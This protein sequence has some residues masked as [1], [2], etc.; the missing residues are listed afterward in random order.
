MT[1]TIAN[2][3]KQ[4]KFTRNDAYDV[5]SIVLIA[6]S[7]VM[8]V[9]RFL[10]VST[11]LVQA[12]KDLAL[13]IAFYFTEL[14][15]F[16]GVITPTVSVIPD[17]LQDILPRT[18]E[19]FYPILQAYGKAL[20]SW[21]DIKASVGV[22]LLNTANVLSI[23]FM[24][25]PLLLC[26]GWLVVQAYQKPNNDY[27]KKTKP[28]ERFERFEEKR[29][30]PVKEYVCGY[31]AYIKEHTP[32][33][34]ILAFLWLYNLNV[35]TIAVEL[36][37]YLLYLCVALTEIPSFIRSLYVQIV[38]LVCDL[39]VMFGFFPWWVFA[40]IG[41]K[42]FDAIRQSIGMAALRYYE[43]CNR[44]FL[45]VYLGALFLVGKQ[46]SKKTTIITDMALTQEII[47]REEARERLSARDK[48]FPFFPWQ[49]V[50]VFYRLTQK[51]HK[52]PTLA[53]YRA[54]VKKLRTTFEQARAGLITKSQEKAMRRRFK[55]LYGYD[56]TNLLFSYDYEKYGLTY[57]DNLTCISIFE[58]IEA[59]IQLFYIYAAPTS[60]LFGNY[61][62]R[63]DLM[64]VD[65]GNFP[66]FDG[67]FFSRSAEEIEELSQ[68]NHVANLDGFRLGN[69]FDET[70]PTRNGFEVG[71]LVVT[72]WAKE[73]GN[74]NT[75][76]GVKAS[77]AGVNAKNDRFEE[78][79]KMQGHASTIDNYTFFRFL[80]DDQRPDSLGADNKD[81]CDVIMI[82]GVSDPKIVMP[83]FMF[84]EWLYALATKIHDKIYYSLR[85]LR[86]DANN[87][88]LVYLMK[89]LYTPIFRH[90]DRISK[91]YSVYTAD[92]KI[93]DAMSDEVLKNKGKY[94]IS[95]KKTYSG[96]FATD[97]IK[98]FYNVKA[99][100][101]EAGTNDFPTFAGRYMSISEMEEVKSLFY[102]RMIKTFMKQELSRQV[103][104]QTQAAEKAEKKSA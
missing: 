13:S 41:F 51:N 104:K 92:L 34:K 61:P 4:E 71:G 28:R 20:I 2:E 57:V 101:S 65:Y 42:I 26:V 75:N 18:W 7:V 84:E 70:D 55:K 78:N 97:G 15:G 63:T 21:E 91:L 100:T 56:Y 43:A 49:N 32:A 8:S 89:K 96:R 29:W 27:R 64:W 17:N 99:L 98:E 44:L 6:V 69:V 67:D 14:S 10:P 37:A 90:Y 86:G 30:K 35:L 82:R 23:V 16:E 47:F 24:F 72:E 59:Y 53:S 73:R 50:E 1:T 85:H 74:Q 80:L 79:M 46:R 22:L 9:W 33:L 95:M 76:A 81:L 11:R 58:A 40:I 3:E 25:L 66:V 52:F 45:T 77:D 93:W 83:G 60:L 54:F 87:T 48:Q 31:V 88:L 94:Y 102:S 62:I 5:I 103:K 38:K 36:A 12:I 39:S 19:E 68:Y